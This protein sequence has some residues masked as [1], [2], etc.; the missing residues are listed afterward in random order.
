VIA[1]GG[2][3]DEDEPVVYC[4]RDGTWWAGRYVG[5]INF[6]GHQLTILPRFGIKVLRDWLFQVTKVA[7]FEAPGRLREDEAFIVQLLAIV[8]AR[9]FVE[10]TRHGLPALRRDAHFHGQAI[11]GRIDVGRSLRSIAACDSTLA[12]T[13]RERSLDNAV[14]SVIVAAYS[15]LNRW[16]GRCGELW[17]PSRARELLPQLL[18]VT[19]SR[20][21]VPTEAELRR[22]R[23]TPITERF[24]A[25]AELSRQIATRHGLASDYS[26]GGK[27]QG[28]LLDVAELWELYV[29]GVLRRVARGFDVKHG[30]SASDSDHLLRQRTGRAM[31][32]LKPDVLIMKRGRIIGIVDAKYKSL[33]PTAAAPN[34]PRREDLYQVTAYLTRYGRQNARPWGALIYPE[35]STEFGVS[36]AEVGNPWRLENAADVFFL[37][38]SHNVT[39]ATNK[40]I[41]EFKEHISAGAMAA[42]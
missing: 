39:E 40:L 25:L 6:E 8:W 26:P 22:V 10:A 1:F 15:V 7:L 20:P 18:S 27:C 3:R 16:V 19:G 4:E 2:Y 5:A 13:R 24:R 38:L 41:H 36:P 33:W 28:V 30:T 21:I 31:G 9:S 32:A 35:D 42:V 37:T 34:G 14:S 23:Y 12:S 11:R 17:L 29:L